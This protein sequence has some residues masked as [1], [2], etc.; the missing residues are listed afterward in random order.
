MSASIPEAVQRLLDQLHGVHPNGSRGDSWEALCPVPAHADKHPSLVVS[1]GDSG[2]P[3]VH[4]RVGCDAREVY[5]AAGVDFR[6]LLKTPREPD[7]PITGCTL[8]EYAAA[9]RL[10]PGRLVDRFKLSDTVYSGFPAVRLRYDNIEGSEAADCERWRVNVTGKRAVRSGTGAKRWPYNLY[11]GVEEGQLQ[12]RL[13]LVEGESDTHTLDLHGIPA[14][15]IPGAKAWDDKWAPFLDG[16]ELIYAVV[17]PDRGGSAFR[18]A[19]ASSPLRDR[20]RFIGLN[21]H[22]DASEL[23]LA[24]LN[25]AK[26]MEAINAAMDASEPAVWVA[27][28]AEEFMAE[29]AHIEA[30][31]FT[32]LP[33]YGIALFTGQPRSFKSMSALQC[34]YAAAT[35]GVFL[36]RDCQRPGEVL[37]VI[38]DEDQRADLIERMVAFEKA[39]PGASKRIRILYHRGVTLT[40][41]ASIRLMRDTLD[42]MTNPVLLVLDTWGQLRDGDENDSEVTRINLDPIKA[43]VRDYAL[44]SIVVHH[45]AKH[46]K[47]RAGD[48][49]RGSGALYGASN[50]VWNFKADVIDEVAQKSGWLTIEPKAGATEQV[51]FAWDSDT[52]LVSVGDEVDV[53]VA[54]LRAA[55][56]RTDRKGTGL[57]ISEIEKA[58]PA[59]KHPTL[60]TRL[61]QAVDEGELTTSGKGA[62]TKYHMPAVVDLARLVKGF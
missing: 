52:F 24:T 57:K 12:G 8:P 3:L 21:P 4:C 10:D 15:G 30:A 23:H 28:T 34:S 54:D 50:A 31:L 7:E 16:I 41:P 9:K 14:V 33:A 53:S 43:I 59:V 2:K 56:E 55:V 13:I 38:E 17:E 32:G 58:L 46:A 35:G 19:L 60:R 39:Y 48:R 37:Y 51:K 11:H 42:T 62:G 18:D 45:D 61:S 1:V 36:N 6:D 44:L 29:V 47:G 22:K 25:H 20:L 27:P 40:S 5:R 49:S 26:F